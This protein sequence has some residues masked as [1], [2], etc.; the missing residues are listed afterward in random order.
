[1]AYE[2][3]PQCGSDKHQLMACPACGFTRL[4]R[5]D[6]SKTRISNRHSE[7]ACSDTR[8]RSETL[9]RDFDKLNAPIHNKRSTN[10]TEPAH[11]ASNIGKKI[12]KKSRRKLSRTE[13]LKQERIRSKLVVKK[14]DENLTP[15]QMAAREKIQKQG[16]HE[17]AK[18]P[19]SNLRKIDK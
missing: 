12:G 3:C 5:F 18:V 9:R 6:A 10:T 17:G 11:G 7:K 15:G 2:K 4:Q 14:K 1:M 19:G 13:I 16:F 8:N